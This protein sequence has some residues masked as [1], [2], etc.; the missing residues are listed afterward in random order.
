MLVVSFI[1]LGALWKTPQLERHATGRDLGRR[2]AGSSS[3]RSA[4]PS[5]RSPSR[6]SARARL[7]ALRHDRPDREPRSD[8]DLRHLLA[9]RAVALRCCSATS[10]GRS[11]PGGRWPTCSC[12]SGSDRARGAAACA[13]TPSGSGASPAA[14]ALFAFVALEL[15]LLRSRPSPRV[16]ALR[17][18]AS[19]RT[20]RSSAWSR[21][22]ARPGRAGR[23]VRDPLRLHRADRAARSRGWAHTPADATHGARGSGAGRRARSSSSRW[24]SARS[25]STATAARSR[26]RTWLIRVE[27]PYI[28]DRP[29]TADCSSSASTSAGSSSRIAFILAR[30]SSRACCARALD[31]GG[32]AVAR[33]RVRRSRSSRSRS[34][35]PSRIT[36]RCS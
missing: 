21:S 4:S 34:S 35:T 25:A 2:S 27:A 28:L 7:G 30:V 10:G 32:A 26:G 36:S 12:G 31:G 17:D 5:R 1:A 15:C 22:A 18:R 6:S 20:S 9:R 29:G 24:R 3:G 19:T 14:V 8:V 33:A 16:L 11:A 13:R 23:G